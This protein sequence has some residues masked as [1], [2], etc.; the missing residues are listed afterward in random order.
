MPPIDGLQDISPIVSWRCVTRMVLAPARAAAAAA[1]HPAWPPPM[2]ITSAERVVVVGP[3]PSAEELL[4]LLLHS[5]GGV[6]LRCERGAARLSEEE[7]NDAS[8]RARQAMSRTGCLN[9]VMTSVRL[10]RARGSRV[11]LAKRGKN[12]VNLARS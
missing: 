5:E 8:A 2:T 4:L 10:V 1:S 3:P 12:L 11:S 9:M 6:A 7:T